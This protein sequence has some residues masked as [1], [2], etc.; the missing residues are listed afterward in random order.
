MNLL[1]S[2]FN[3]LFGFIF[4]PFENINPAWGM[5]CI[6]LVTGI[7]MLV[8][9]R[10]TS[11]QQGI[12]KAKAK[13]GAYIL[14]MRLFSHDLGKMLA[15]LGKTLLAN[16][17]YLRYMIVPLILII[18]PVMI[19]LIQLSYRYENRPLQ[20]GEPVIVKAVLK[21]DFSVLET[22][23]I[24]QTPED[25]LVETPALRISLLN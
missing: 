11:N 2:G 5:I 3:A 21:P 14:E 13:V 7:I 18:V 12:K 16:L 22:P 17:F 19:V 20:T 24:L 6:S 8:I 15:S 25:V 10:Y 4:Y 9:F 1:F 23:V